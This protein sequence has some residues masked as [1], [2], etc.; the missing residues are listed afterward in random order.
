M[1]SEHFLYN[2]TAIV[3]DDDDLPDTVEDVDEDQ[4]EGDQQGHPARHHLWL[5]KEADP[6]NNHKHTARQ[7][8]LQHY[9]T[10]YGMAGTPTHLN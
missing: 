10:R 8:H 6:A 3:D 5:D 1:I 4:E 2:K 7:V 9:N